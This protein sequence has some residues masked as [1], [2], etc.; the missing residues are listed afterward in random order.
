[1]EV[2]GKD[3]ALARTFPCPATGRPGSSGRGT[4]SSCSSPYLC[5][6]RLCNGAGMVLQ[7]WGCAWPHACAY[8]LRSVAMSSQLSLYLEGKGGWL[9]WLCH[10]GAWRRCGVVRRFQQ[11]NAD[12]YYSARFSR[13]SKVT[14]CCITSTVVGPLPPAA[15]APPMPR[16]APK[17]TPPMFMPPLRRWRGKEG[18]AR[19]GEGM[20]GSW[21]T[22]V[23]LEVSECM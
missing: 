23:W 8:D 9:C 16:P 21:R 7:H 15:T 18:G 20:W 1:M 12:Y 13:S 22:K 2:R 5:A 11:R 19:G 6:A 4:S 10:L 17:P 3:K 14:I